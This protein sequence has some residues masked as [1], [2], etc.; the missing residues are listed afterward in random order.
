MPDIYLTIII[1]WVSAVLYALLLLPIVLRTAMRRKLYD[2]PDAR[3][4]HTGM[5]PRLG[6]VAFLPAFLL[7]LLTVV[8]ADFLTGS[9]RIASLFVADARRVVFATLALCV[10]YGTGIADDII[11]SRY[12]TKFIMQL[13]CGALLICGGMWIGGF[14]GVLGVETLPIWIAWPFTLVMTVF[15]IN[16]FNLIDGI[17]GLSAMLTQT[18]MIFYGVICWVSRDWTGVI[19]AAA[20]IGIIIPFLR[21]NLFGNPMRGTKLFMGDCGSMTLGLLCGLMGLRILSA[22]SA[23]QVTGA[24]PAMLAL[25]PIMI[26]CFDVVRVYFVRIMQHRSPFLPDRSHIHHRLLDLGLSPHRTLLTLVC[27][28]A[29][30]A[31]AN[32]ILSIYLNINF[33]FLLD[34]IIWCIMT[35]LL[36][37]RGLKRAALEGRPED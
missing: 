36:R 2:T 7:A 26:P 9:G 3:K 4:V 34:I 28:S 8:G 19:I 1:S 30:V 32:I 11:G 22:G 10:I 31:A 12:S 16:A 21:Y 13:L 20:A 18:A 5:V 24:N 27:A 37:H 17:D 6:G 33:L 15:I 35:G 14:Y 29:I 23:A 25:A